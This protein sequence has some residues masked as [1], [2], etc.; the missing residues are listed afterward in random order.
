MVL[1]LSLVDGLISD[2]CARKV[3]EMNSKKEYFDL[4][5]LKEP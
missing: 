5:T 2:E 3:A 4:S 1:L